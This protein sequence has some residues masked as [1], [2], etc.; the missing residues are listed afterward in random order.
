MVVEGVAVAIAVVVIEDVAK[1]DGVEGDV[2]V[3]IGNVVILV[4]VAVIGEVFVISSI[5]VAFLAVVAIDVITVGTAVDAVFVA[6]N[7]DVVVKVPAVVSFVDTVTVD[8]FFLTLSLAPSVYFC[9]R[10]SKL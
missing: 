10:E 4:I 3:E 6:S 5:V 8:V 7:F 2:E 1:I 9:H